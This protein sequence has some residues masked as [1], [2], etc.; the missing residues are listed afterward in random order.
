MRG[1]WEERDGVLRYRTRGGVELYRLPTRLFPE[2]DGYV[3]LILTDRHRILVDAGSGLPESWEDL[4]RGLEIVRARYGRPVDLPGLTA[5]LITHGHIDH[6]GGLTFVRQQSPAPVFVHELDRRVLVN[7]P[8]RL[9]TVAR[10]LRY[11]LSQAGVSSE[12]QVALLNLYLS[13]KTMF[14]ST[15]VEGLLTDGE[16]LFGILRVH[17]VPGHCPGQV[18]LQ[19]DEVLLTSDHILA[20]TTP[21]QAPERITRYTGLGHYLESLH[22][23]AAI[24]DIALAFGGHEDPILNPYERIAAIEAFHHQRLERVLEI[25]RE[26]H[27]IMEISMALFGRQYGYGVLLALLEAGAHVEYLYDRGYLQVANLDQLERDPE[28]PIRYRRL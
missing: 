24:P 26:P 22:R 3:Y 28:A 21:H 7:Y 20:H 25:C 19:I 9:L 12:R 6:F 15:S 16:L 1:P 5:I 8:E 23:V 18:C 4:Q 17:H 10:E 27:T 13:M 14:Q 2:L 11:F